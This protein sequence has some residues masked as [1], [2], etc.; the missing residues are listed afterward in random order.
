MQWL[1]LPL[2]VLAGLSNPIQ[3]AA[4]AG[5]N[6]SLGQVA[7]AALVIYG[8]AIVG[9]LLCLPVL[10]WTLRDFG[11]KLTT[12]PW[13]A[14]IGGLCNL[15]FV[16]AGALCTQKLGSATFTVTVAC[17]AIV[18]SMILDRLGLMGLEQHPITWLRVLGGA[19]AVGGI[20]LV[21][22]S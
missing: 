6:K 5:L 13:W 9:L 20:A 19:L 7:A 12:V 10:G 21:S 14:W 22:L 18:L 8:V 4:N 16:I 2:A 11:G 15:S 17:S 1:L 3:S